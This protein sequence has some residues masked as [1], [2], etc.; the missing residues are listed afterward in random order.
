MNNKE[1]PFTS[2]NVINYL[3]SSGIDV[4]THTKARGNSGIYL[5]GRIDV[6]K[7]LNEDKALEVLVHEFA[8]HI[9]SKIDKDF[10]KTGG[11]I[12]TLF[13]L[14]N[15]DSADLIASELLKIT[16]FEDRIEKLRPFFSA[17]E[18]VSKQIKNLQKSIQN[19][20]PDFQ[21]SKK[22]KEFD[23][24]VK[25]TDAAYL[26]EYDAVKIKSGFF[27]KKERIISVQTIETDFPDM[28]E[29]FK[30]YIRLRALKRKQAR[31]SR[32]INRL[33]KYFS[34]PAELFARFVQAC[35]FYPDDAKL[36]APN[37]YSQFEM[38]LNNGYFN[39]LKDFFEIFSSKKV[40]TN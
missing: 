32:R 39:E 5:P 2:Q 14:Y 9:H 37:A 25:N 30:S 27:R 34:R 8:H 35:F 26:A 19:Y 31:L 10:Y 33:D 11:S 40:L 29:A 6:S 28:P 24:Y 12:Q 36:K 23:K 3:R 20:Y 15:N 1:K 22:F 16:D 4:K 13:C 18:N 17:K 38:L 21:R 7:T